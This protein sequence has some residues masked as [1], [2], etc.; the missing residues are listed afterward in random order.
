LN[1]N[2]KMDIKSFISSGILEAYILGECSPT[3]QRDV[4][5][6]M[7]Q[8]PE[9]RAELEQLEIQ[10]ESVAKQLAVQPSDGLRQRV[11]DRVHTEAQTPI[12]PPTPTSGLGGGLNL[13]FLALALSGLLGLGYF[14]F[15][16]RNAQAQIAQQTSS[17]RA[18]EERETRM[19][20]ME[21]Q[22]VLLNSAS[23]RRFEILPLAEGATAR[24]ATVF[25]DPQTGSCLLSIAGM[26]TA[27]AGKSFQLW[28]LVNGTP[29]SMGVLDTLND[30]TQFRELACRD[31]AQAYA[32]SIEVAGGSP[33][34]T[35]V[36]MV[37]KG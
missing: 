34:P 27:P 32:I 36:I 26:D 11:L 1:F 3:E 29:V 10:M 8:H 16:N 2:R 4:E 12:K 20:T 23:T 6:M 21:R 5:R 22:I 25:K 31:D 14:W 28:A 13:G 17:L 15:Q 37:S 24:A 35:E 18:C 9:V 33:N 30:K 19:Q 7:A